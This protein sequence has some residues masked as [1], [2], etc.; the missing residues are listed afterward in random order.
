M[1][2]FEQYHLGL[3][4]YA[5]IFDFKCGHIHLIK[6]KNKSK[7][8]QRT[9]YE[10]IMKLKA[11]SPIIFK[12]ALLFYYARKTLYKKKYNYIHLAAAH[13]TNCVSAHISCV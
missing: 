5:E 8:H 7:V 12:R 2:N 10:L 4:S 9:F 3:E 11:G 1:A 13:P 6:F